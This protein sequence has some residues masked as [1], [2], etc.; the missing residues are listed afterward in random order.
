MDTI[1]PAMRLIDALLSRLEPLPSGKKLSV[2]FEE[3][4]LVDA[5]WRIC[6]NDS[7]E[8]DVAE[9]AA[10]ILD[11]YYEGEDNDDVEELLAPSSTGDI[12][13]FHAPSSFA[14]VGGFD[15]SSNNPTSS[16]GEQQEPRPQMG[17]GRGRG[18][19][20]PA[21]MQESQQT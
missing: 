5:L 6:D 12:F 16:V 18:Q 17:R 11:E 15:F 14:P 8:S 7:D 3:V 4:G 1:Y 21:W 13:Q 19:Q 20:I 2:I 9:M 10:N